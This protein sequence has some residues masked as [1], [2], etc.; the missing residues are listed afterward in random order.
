[1]NTGPVLVQ[2]C[3][4]VNSNTRQ[5]KATLSHPPM[6]TL[7]KSIPTLEATINAPPPPLP[8]I[9]VLAG[10]I[11]STQCDSSKP[12]LSYPYPSHC[13]TSR[14]TLLHPQSYHFLSLRLSSPPPLLTLF[15]SFTHSQSAI[16]GLSHT[17]FLLELTFPRGLRK[18]FHR[19]SCHLSPASSHP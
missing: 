1:M 13:A 16:N 8:R 4:F 2:L 19:T 7:I 18:I 14:A 5:R 12:S 10:N 15:L 3:L 9:P 6:C 11:N 17:R